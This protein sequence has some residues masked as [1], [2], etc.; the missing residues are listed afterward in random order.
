MG[1]RNEAVGCR[2]NGRSSVVE[3]FVGDE[4]LIHIFG[5]KREQH[6]NSLEIRRNNT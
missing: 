1:V 3:E 4:N 5:G 2:P 6:T